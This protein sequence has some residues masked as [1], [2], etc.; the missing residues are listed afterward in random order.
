M[1]KNKRFDPSEFFPYRETIQYFSGSAHNVDDLYH[2]EEYVH[3]YIYSIAG[4][5]SLIQ[6]M[7]RRTFL[8]SV[9]VPC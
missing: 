6:N 4:Y 5:T 3:R 1:D 2:R 9:W 8:L 7:C